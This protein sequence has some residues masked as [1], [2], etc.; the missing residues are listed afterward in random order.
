MSEQ[1]TASAKKPGSDGDLQQELAEDIKSWTKWTYERVQETKGMLDDDDEGGGEKTAELRRLAGRLKNELRNLDNMELRLVVAAPMSAG[2]ST[3]I[4]AVIGEELLPNRNSAMTVFPTEIRLSSDSERPE[5]RLSGELI[6][7]FSHSVRQIVSAAQEYPDEQL[8]FPKNPYLEELLEELQQEHFQLSRVT[9]TPSNIRQTLEALS[10]INRL[11]A[12]LCPQ[13]EPIMRYSSELTPVIEVPPRFPKHLE[14]DSF[15]SLVIVDTPGPNEAGGSNLFNVLDR[16]LD[17]GSMVLL[18]LDYTQINSEAEAKIREQISGVLEYSPDENFFVVA[19][20]IDQRRNGMSF[21]DIGRFV[22]ADL[23][24]E[25]IAESERLFE[26]SAIQALKASQCSQS[27]NGE[28]EIDWDNEI[29]LEFLKE[30]TNLWKRELDE[31]K[32][33]PEGKARERLTRNSNSLWQSS[34]FEEFVDGVVG[35][36]FHRVGK[37]IL[38]TSCD[39]S[40]AALNQVREIVELRVGGLHADEETLKQNLDELRTEK[41][42]LAKTR[43]KLDEHA[44]RR[45]REIR[46]ELTKKKTQ[47][48]NPAREIVREKFR[49]IQD[50]E[51]GSW[52]NQLV[53][54]LNSAT[55]GREEIEFR[56]QIEARTAAKEIRNHVNG[57]IL[58]STNTQAERMKHELYQFHEQIE[59]D[60]NEAIRPIL[61]KAQDKLE[62]NFDV[63]L[64]SPDFELTELSSEAVSYSPEQSKKDYTEEKTVTRR[65]KVFYN[66]FGLLPYGEEEVTEK[67][68]K[69]R[70]VYKVSLKT[71]EQKALDAV[72][73]QLDGLQEKLTSHLEEELGEAI[74][75]FMTQAEEV[76]SRYENILESSLKDQKRTVEKQQMLKSNLVK[77]VE[78]ARERRKKLKKHG[79]LLF[80]GETQS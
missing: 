24:I 52:I 70:T 11:A 47:W 15:G 4:N 18:V 63:E 13:A 57:A 80:H 62:E 54:R 76:F 25:G 23:G 58:S 41:K 69:I 51:E 9:K 43:T 74:D 37:E 68:E 79:E 38:R 71:V 5:L 16:E 78:K 61:K 75:G 56:N 59:K 34:G 30:L 29:L 66:L 40:S 60:C 65:K 42:K 31:L 17:Y 50:R 22:E 14:E 64:V 73:N 2:K 33:L 28:D 21:E 10:D 67:E 36:L 39:V 49:Q 45:L 1:A 32:A 20:K 26:T 53:D 44:T 3:L 27:V 8:Q 46:C 6:E 48:K 7:L 35:Y 77:M 12:R 19:N 55:F 72:D